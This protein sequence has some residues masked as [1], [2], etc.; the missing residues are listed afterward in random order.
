MGCL[1]ARQIF[2]IEVDTGKGICYPLPMNNTE[3]T[4]KDGASQFQCTSFPYAF[5]QMYNTIKKGVES[6][7]KYDDM[8][9]SMSILSPVKDQH[10]DPRIYSYTAAAEMATAQGLLTADG[11]INS[12][13][14][15]RRY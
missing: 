3:W 12:R 7:R 9:K 13:E 10:G 8:V 14:F 5:R 11:Q 1:V 2:Q 15:K 6:G 4:F